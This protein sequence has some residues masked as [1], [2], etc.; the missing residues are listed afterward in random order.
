MEQTNGFAPCQTE[1]H[2]VPKS[3]PRVAHPPMWFMVVT[4]VVI[5]LVYGQTAFSQC[6]MVCHGSVTVALDSDGL[7]VLEEV[8]LLQTSTSNCSG[9]FEINVFD[10]LG[11][12]YGNEMDGSL[13][14]EVLTAAI[15]HLD[16]GNQCETDLTVTD[17]TPPEFTAD[18]LF[19][20]CNSPTDPEEIGYPEINDNVSKGGFEIPKPTSVAHDC[21]QSHYSVNQGRVPL[22]A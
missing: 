12:N 5:M 13:I 3:T 6:P 1:W 15:I 14:N 18:T 2:T 22:H 7:Y 16:T 4:S 11:N 17:N 20:Y 10:T 21:V 19:I 8:D 9:D